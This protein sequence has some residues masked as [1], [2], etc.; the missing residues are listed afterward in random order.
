MTFEQFDRHAE[1]VFEQIREMGRTKGQEYANGNAGRF[2]NFDRL[3]LEL[4]MDRKQVLWVYLQKHLDA[5]RSYIRLGKTL[6]T[7]PIEGRIL[8]ALV[9]LLLLHGMVRE[10][11]E[12]ADD[13]DQLRLP[14][15][16]SISGNR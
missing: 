12:M 10:D 9:Y 2:G 14:Q 11:L 1:Q 6:S 13:L 15:I 16:S 3:A 4:G 7:E 5:M 8:D